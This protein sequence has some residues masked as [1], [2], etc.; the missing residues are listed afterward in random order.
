MATY[1]EARPEYRKCD[2]TVRGQIEAW[3]S[4]ACWQ[5]QSFQDDWRDLSDYVLPR[6]DPLLHQE[7]GQGEGYGEGYGRASPGYSQSGTRT[8]QRGPRNTKRVEGTAQ[9]AIQTTASGLSNGTTPPNDKWFS[10]VPPNDFKNPGKDVSQWISDSEDLLY[11]A[12]RESGLYEHLPNMYRELCL[13]G[14]SALGMF[15]DEET[16]F[17]FEPYE[18]GSYWLQQDAKGKI[19]G[20]YRIFPMTIDQIVDE[21]CMKGSKVDPEQFD[22]LSQQAKD[23]WKK[24]DQSFDFEMMECIIP[25]D[26]REYDDGGTLKHGRMPFVHVIYERS[27]EDV[28]DDKESGPRILFK[29]GFD[30]FPILTPRWFL[31]PKFPWGNSPGMNALDDIIQLQEMTSVKGYALQKMVDPPVVAS[32]NMKGEALRLTPGAAN[33]DPSIGDPSAGVRPVYQFDPRLDHFTADIEQL[34][35]AVSSALYETLFLIMTKIDRSNVT[36]TEVDARQQEKLTQLEEVLTRLDAD[37]LKPLIYGSFGMMLEGGFFPEVPEELDGLDLKVKYL[38]MIAKIQ[39]HQSLAKIRE[40]VEFVISVAERQAALG[41]KDTAI[42]ML[43]ADASIERY[44][45][46]MGTPPEVLL[47]QVQ[48]RVM[49]SKRDEADAAAAR[50]DEQMMQIAAAKEL[51]QIPTGPRPGENMAADIASAGAGVPVPAPAER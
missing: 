7:Y 15:E 46:D 14:T 39:R 2:K 36:A 20:F 24:R 45:R 17:R 16:A 13:F 50:M 37:F 19:N 51:A 43:D 41:V 9:R 26:D 23:A 48:V 5:R 38:S 22:M 12:F 25:A 49:R 33:F 28:K 35:E 29:G 44:A 47:S 40:S 32:P 3:W 6:T 31:N 8:D 42:D 11:D 1:K 30:K 21:Y 4:D 27:G 10:L 34:K 18:I